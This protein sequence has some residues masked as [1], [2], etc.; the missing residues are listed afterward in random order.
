M[1]NEISKAIMTK[2][3]LR[4]R[5]LKNRSNRNRSI[6]QAK[7]LCVSLKK[8]CFSKLNEKQITDNKRF[9]KAV[10]PFLSKKVQSSEKINLT[11][12]NNSLVA[13]CGKIAK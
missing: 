6:L 8:Y 9:W 5:F 3:R 11:E 2:T 1:N 10:K 7:K 13:D 12:E 4:N